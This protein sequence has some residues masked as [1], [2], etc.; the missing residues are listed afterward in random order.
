M[1]RTHATTS[2]HVRK[3]RPEESLTL[4]SLTVKTEKT[5]R[6][7]FRLG[8]SALN[9]RASERL[10]PVQNFDV[11]PSTELSTSV[12]IGTKTFSFIVPSVL[13]ALAGYRIL[14]S[15]NVNTLRRQKK[16]G[17]TECIYVDNHR[18]STK[19]LLTAI[20]TLNIERT[21]R[22]CF[23]CVFEPRGKKEKSIFR[24]GVSALNHRA[25]ERLI[26]VNPH[27]HT[28][29]SF[30][31]A[32]CLFTPKDLVWLFFCFATLSCFVLN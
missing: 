4:S 19:N 32:S 10:I 2:I 12:E 24:S 6:K 9:H 1:R 26:P 17:T 28:H 11:S 16:I 21:L 3:E 30:I 23:F 14:H 20:K 7:Q 13:V 31:R 15:T 22:A 25:S 8:V 18:R 27:T 5:E 29:T